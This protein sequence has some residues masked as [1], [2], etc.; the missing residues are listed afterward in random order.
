MIVRRFLSVFAEN[1]AVARAKV[2]VA[3]GNEKYVATG[4]R[5]VKPGWLEY[6]TYAR[7]DEHMLPE[8]KKGSSCKSR[9]E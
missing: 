5:I 2:V 1:A 8:F 4:S 9:R 6:Y 7:I 3:I